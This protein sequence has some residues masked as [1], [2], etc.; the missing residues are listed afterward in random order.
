[1]TPDYYKKHVYCPMCGGTENSQTLVNY[2]GDKDENRVTCECGWVG[3][4]DDLV[5]EDDSK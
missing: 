4:V 1:M 5:A 3:I 2:L